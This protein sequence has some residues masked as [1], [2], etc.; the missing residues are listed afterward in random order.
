MKTK[1]KFTIIS[2]L[3][4]A[5]NP[6]PPK[7]E[8]TEPKINPKILI[9]CNGI[10]EVKLKDSY[11]D[12][13][14][15]FKVTEHENNVLGQYISVNDGKPNQI[16]IY[17]LE[18][19]KPFKRIKYLETSAS[20][21]P[22]KTQSGLQIGISVD[23]LQKMNGYLPL[24]FNNF[25]TKNKPGELL[26]FN[27]GN[28]SKSDPCIGGVVDIESMHNV[29]INELNTFQ[30]QKLVESSDHLLNRIKVSLVSIRVYNR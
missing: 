19:H 4:A 20:D 9:S 28:F 17:W 7:K 15:K 24:T 11:Q 27:N 1:L 8:P 14:K 2:L 23:T 29:D 5:C 13:T 22:F 18:K 30:K 25:Y 12:I 3:F 10:G 21:S 26:R 6:N 16:N